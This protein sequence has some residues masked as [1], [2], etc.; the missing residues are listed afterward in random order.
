MARRSG[1]HLPR[2]AGLAAA[3]VFAWVP[4]KAQSALDCNN[5]LIETVST[6]QIP[7]AVRIAI[8]LSVADDVF[9]VALGNLKA[10]PGAK[11]G[12]VSLP[13][14]PRSNPPPVPG[15]DPQASLKDY[16]A[17]R[18][19]FLK[20]VRYDFS[21]TTPAELIRAYVGPL[22]VGSAGKPY[23][24]CLSKLNKPLYLRVVALSGGQITIELTFK[25]PDP[26]A[27]RN[28]TVTV[29]GADLSPADQGWLK[30]VDQTPSISGKQFTLTPKAGM[31]VGF[32]VESKTDGIGDA[33]VIPV[34]PPVLQSSQPVAAIDCNLAL[35]WSLS[36][37][38]LP[39]A[40]RIA[41]DLSVT[42]DD[43]AIAIGNLKA[44]PGA[45]IGDVALTPKLPPAKAA[46]AGAK[47]GAAKP[48]DKAQAAVAPGPA[49][50]APVPAV[51]IWTDYQT[52]RDAFLKTVKYDL[53]TTTTAELIRAY[54]GPLA[55]GSAADGY[56][57][58]LSG[59]RLLYL[60]V[61]SLSSGQ[62][63]I[64]LNA[65]P[66]NANDTASR[67]LTV[68]VSGADLSPADQGW[69]KGVDQPPSIV[70]KQFMLTHKAN[71]PV[72]FSV[73]SKAGDVSDAIV[74]PL[75]PPV[76]KQGSSSQIVAGNRIFEGTRYGRSKQPLRTC[77]GPDSGYKLG[78]SWPGLSQDPAGPEN[79]NSD[80]P[81][82]GTDSLCY[83]PTA[84]TSRRPTWI[85]AQ[86]F[87]AETK[88]TWSTV[89]QEA[90]WSPK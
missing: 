58:C 63:T 47:P 84:P 73:E 55:T 64:E 89:A 49:P 81:V 36:T 2:V 48:K 71:M 38:Q 83:A 60:R 28:L 56:K 65:V 20:T 82:S 33:I 31:P 68:T 76:Q 18:E 45:Q 25:L 72:T 23:A 12:D 85:D 1:S 88:T 7:A 69:L 43:F 44:I 50:L 90:D 16:Q 70:G 78:K 24:D 19:A 80:K 3:A 4:A 46:P 29:S 27:S 41:V 61:V 59:Q 52:R 17:A 57:T 21:S 10:I 86:A 40:A 74:I 6:A 54:A 39:A 32:S 34:L 42:E 11:L 9:G 75:L 5:A 79:P 66:L 14:P 22:A 15:G 53:S 87:A 13:P 35:V 51:L 30:G 67:N 62:V 8:D 77:V 26:T 37:A